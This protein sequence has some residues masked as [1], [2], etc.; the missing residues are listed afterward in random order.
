[1]VPSH[2]LDAFARVG[3]GEHELPQLLIEPFVRH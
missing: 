3:Q 2:V 1:V